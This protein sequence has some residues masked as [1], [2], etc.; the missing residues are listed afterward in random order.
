MLKSAHFPSVYGEKIIFFVAQK[1]ADSQRVTFAKV[2]VGRILTIEGEKVEK[3]AVE[4]KQKVTVLLKSDPK[5]WPF[6]VHKILRISTLKVVAWEKS[7]G[8]WSLS[9]NW[10]QKK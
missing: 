3:W 10:K 4:P 8:H 6:G 1:C 7:L 9:I 2:T 5:K